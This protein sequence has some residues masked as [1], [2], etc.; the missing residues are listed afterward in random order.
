MEQEEYLATDQRNT[1]AL[2][3]RIA[4]LETLYDTVE[5]INLKYSERIT[6]L[7]TDQR[8][9]QQAIKDT[10]AT[11]KR[12][13][14]LLAEAVFLMRRNPDMREIELLKRI[15]EELSGN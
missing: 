4:E 9:D 6:E 11:C 2:R 7:E 14:D 5:T 10:Q 15:R 12:L 1:T 3:N 13:A 8:N